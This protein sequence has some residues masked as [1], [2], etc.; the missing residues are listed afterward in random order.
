M[1]RTGKTFMLFQ[2]IRR[3]LADQVPIETILYLNFEDDRL[4]PMN[5]SE[6]AK[7]LDA[8]YSLY[9]ENHEK[10]CYLFLDE[11]QNVHDWPI[12][13]RRFLDSKK[14]KI[15]LTGSSAKLLS[16]EIATSLRGR[17]I[18]TEIWPYS[19]REYLTAHGFTVMPKVLGR[20]TSMF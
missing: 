3:L 7:L 6:L 2:E 12:V 9:P 13:I 1:R 10:Q 20:K 18:A 11:I 14:V 4:L 8:F 19:F 15:Y 16:K 5:K 17:S